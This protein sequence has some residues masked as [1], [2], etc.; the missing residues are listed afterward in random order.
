[1]RAN[2]L[3]AQSADSAAN[4]AYLLYHNV[5]TEISEETV[6]AAE[7]LAIAQLGGETMPLTEKFVQDTM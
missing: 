1:M 5:M 2:S 4:L 3:D 6:H 7:R